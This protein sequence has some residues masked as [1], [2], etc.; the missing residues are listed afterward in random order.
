[1]TLLAQITADTVEARKARAATSGV[2]IT[3]IGEVET[4]TKTFT[5]ARPL[6]DDEV[7]AI[8]AKF[9]KNI[10]ETLRVLDAERDA[11]AIAKLNAERAV[12]ER[13]LPSQIDEAQ[14][15]A[16]AR[17]RIAAGDA[18]GQVMNSLKTAYAGQY[19][20]KIASGIVKKLLSA[21]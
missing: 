16:F 5:P 9:I 1:M 18:M 7:V 20:G 14:I 3:L 10:D 2:L 15:E 19:D 12:L 21:A 8:V 6:K 13:Y 11:A 4:R 17:E